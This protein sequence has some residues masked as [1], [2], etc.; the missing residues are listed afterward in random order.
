MTKEKTSIHMVLGTPTTELCE[1]ESSVYFT[2]VGDGFIPDATTPEEANHFMCKG[3][4]MGTSSPR[5]ISNLDSLFE[6]VTPHFDTL[7]V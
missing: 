4:Q 5:N 2:R 7:I 6:Q 3:L 1:A